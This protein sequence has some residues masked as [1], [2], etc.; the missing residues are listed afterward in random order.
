[1]RAFLKS[2]AMGA[3]A[4]AWL[5]MIFTVIAAFI[6]ISDRPHDGNAILSMILFAFFP[7]PLALAFVL[8]A[9]VLVGLPVT[10][11]LIR[12]RAE[13]SVAYVVIG[14]AIGFALPLAVLFWMNAS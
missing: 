8:P 3:L 13:T 7:L 1:M 2:V 4:G 9:S 12:F 14:L 6:A 10:A 5:P 11:L